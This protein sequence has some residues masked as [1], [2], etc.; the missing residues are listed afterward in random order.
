MCSFRV[1]HELTVL[2]GNAYVTILERDIKGVRTSLISKG[3]QV[4][5][6]SPSK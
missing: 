6:K 2:D 1:E 5:I 4:P 3:Y